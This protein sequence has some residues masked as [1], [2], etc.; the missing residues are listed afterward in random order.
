MVGTR[1]H[2]P[3]RRRRH[4][5]DPRRQSGLEPANARHRLRG[6]AAGEQR[7]ADIALEPVE[8]VVAFG[9]D[10]PYDGIGVPVRGSDDRSPGAPKRAAPRGRNAW[11]R[12][13]REVSTRSDRLSE[14]DLGHWAPA[15]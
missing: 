10:D 11:R 3:G 13:P 9:A 4:R 1:R 6:P 14:A 12:A 2:T 8:P 7:L 15:P 5:G